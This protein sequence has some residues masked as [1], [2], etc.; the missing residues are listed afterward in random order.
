[1]MNEFDGKENT[2]NSNKKQVNS[3]LNE[4]TKLKT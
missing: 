3:L 4:N 2:L 1:M